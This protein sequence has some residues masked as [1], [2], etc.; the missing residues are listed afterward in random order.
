MKEKVVE[1]RQMLQILAMFMIVQFFGL[2]LAIITF[3][4]ATMHQVAT[5]EIMNSYVEVL[6]YIVYIAIAA[7]ILIL[8]FKY[9]NGRLLFKILE[10]IFILISSFFVFYALIDYAIAN[11]NIAVAISIIAAIALIF[12]KNKFKVLRNTAAIIGSVGI[13]FVLGLTFTFE[14][15]YIFMGILAIYDFIAVFITKH[16]LSLARLA[17]ENNLALMVGVNEIK[18]VPEKEA[19][20]QI[21][22]EAQKEYK[23]SNDQIAQIFKSKKLV[24]ILARLELGNGDLGIPLMVAIAA[25][26]TTMNFVLS[27]FVIF[28]AIIGLI[29]TMAILKRYKRALPAI[30]P[31]F[32]GITIFVGLYMLLF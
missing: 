6:F 27:F 18:G 1:F 11:N 8:I 4:G 21:M 12:A 32:A 16:M 29:A 20:M 22:N 7:A 24:P 23:K 30:P 13:G 19:N 25:Y 10:A 31:L 17:E 5:N 9:I 28:G 26:S 3:S 2:L 15:A 14:T